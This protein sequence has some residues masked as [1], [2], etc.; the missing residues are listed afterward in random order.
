MRCSILNDFAD[1]IGAKPLER[2]VVYKSN[3][4]RTASQCR[5][6]GIHYGWK[7]SNCLD[8]RRSGL[9]TRS[10]ASKSL[11]RVGMTWRNGR[12]TSSPC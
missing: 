8:Q 10:T 9:R 3:T 5:C 2:T 4:I 7:S 1:R 12:A 6:K 11:D